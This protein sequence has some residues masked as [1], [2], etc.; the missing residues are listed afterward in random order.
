M[1]RLLITLGIIFVSL[2]AGYAVRCHVASGRSRFSEDDVVRLRKRLQLVALFFLMPF[3]AMLS[4]WGLPSPDSR[5]LTLPLL[6]VTA[7]IVGGLV[8]IPVARMLGLSR[9][10]TGS[11]YCCATFT[12]LGAVGSLVAVVFLGEST[13]AL[14]A[15]YRLCEEMFYYGVA[16]P[17]AQ[18]YGQAA[19]GQRFSLR[20]LRFDPLLWLVLLALGVGIALNLGGVPRPEAGRIA[21]TVFVLLTTTFFLFAIGLGLRVSRLSGHVRAGLAVSLIKFACVPLVIVSLAWAIGLGDIDNGL[22]LRAVAIFACMPVAMNA[23]VPPSLFNL[24][25]DLANACWIFSTLGLVVV[26]PLLLVLLPLL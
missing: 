2:A 6:G 26:L 4:L 22:P 18:W 5:L 17:V 10:Q 3:S 13:I 1:E 14:A 8:S 25:L 15:L 16:Y 20:G 7:F 19:A 24:D 9:P 12:N 23:L 21:A 11:F